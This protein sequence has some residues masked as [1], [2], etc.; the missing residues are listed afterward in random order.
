MRGREKERDYRPRQTIWFSSLTR[1]SYPGWMDQ[2][3]QVGL[4]ERLVYPY[5]SSLLC[6]MAYQS[7]LPHG[8][9]CCF[10]YFRH[11]GA[12]RILIEVL[13]IGQRRCSNVSVPGYPDTLRRW[14][15]RL[16]CDVGTVFPCRS[17]RDDG[18]V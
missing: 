16:I 7:C 4:H 13:K 14:R 17:I 8:W 10:A 12:C 18:T 3:W 11:S 2:F 6:S 1:Y 9:L 15:V 5:L